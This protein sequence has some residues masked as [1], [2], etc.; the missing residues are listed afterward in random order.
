MLSTG[1]GIVIF[2]AFWYN[3]PV[4]NWGGEGLGFARAIIPL[5]DSLNSVRRCT[6]Q[7]ICH[8][9]TFIGLVPV[10]LSTILSVSFIERGIHND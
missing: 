2:C 4:E 5:F 9:A 6:K 3:I 1:C 8:H 7:A 10:L